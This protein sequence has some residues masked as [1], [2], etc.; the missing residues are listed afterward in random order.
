[1]AQKTPLEDP[2]GFAEDTAAGTARAQRAAT[3]TGVLP[4]SG[5]VLLGTFTRFR[6]ARA[7][8]RTPGGDIAEVTI[9]DRIGGRHV[10]AIEDGTLVLMRHGRT[11]RLTVPGR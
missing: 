4:L 5:V 2:P 7:L 3:Q 9:G 6:G 11:D 10:A 8:I 1:M